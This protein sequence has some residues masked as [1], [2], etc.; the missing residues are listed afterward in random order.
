MGLAR[1]EEKGSPFSPDEFGMLIKHPL[2]GN[3]L[4]RNLRLHFVV[5]PNGN[6]VG[7]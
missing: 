7:T 2:F 6:L 4:D 1:P 3:N 5:Y